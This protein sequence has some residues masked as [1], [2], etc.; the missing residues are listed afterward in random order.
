MIY[1]KRKGGFLYRDSPQT[2]DFVLG[3]VLY[4]SL[5]YH[6]GGISY[7]EMFI[8]VSYFSKGLNFALSGIYPRK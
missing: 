4:E 7:G 6:R 1:H 8:F 2:V 3:V 5:S